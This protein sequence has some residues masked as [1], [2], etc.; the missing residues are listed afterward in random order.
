MT[1]ANT[2]LS[3]AE[4]AQRVAAGKTND[5]PGRASRT[6]QEIVRANVFTRI[7]A[8]LASLIPVARTAIE[9]FSPRLA[10]LTAVGGPDVAA[11]LEFSVDAA[12]DDAWRTA[13]I[14]SLAPSDVRRLVVSAADAKAKLLG[15][16]VADPPEPVG[17]VARH[18]RA[19]ESRDVAAIITALDALA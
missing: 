8:I 19:A 2:G 9:G 4:V 18:I 15:R 14:V 11:A 16:V 17:S 5:V 12:R 7:N 1:A 10:E 3:D 13:T 6:V